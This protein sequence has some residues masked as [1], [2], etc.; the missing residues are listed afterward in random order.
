VVDAVGAEIEVYMDGGI[1][2]GVDIVKALALGAR[3]CLSG[4]ALVYGLAAGGEPGAARAM[5]LLVEE[6]RLAM[7]LAA[8]G[9]V[10]EFDRSWVA[11]T[12]EGERRAAWNIS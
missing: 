6:L 12:P 7:T 2:R 1:R 8:C 5:N 3:A 10:R 11:R 9:S 4:R